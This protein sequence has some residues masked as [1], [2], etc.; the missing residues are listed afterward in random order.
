MT[1]LT[2][3]ELNIEGYRQLFHCLQ[4]EFNFLYIGD[5]LMIPLDVCGVLYLQLIHP[6]FV[7][8]IKHSLPT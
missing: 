8:I 5:Y 6:L 1:S 3:F 7:E 4:D 2:T